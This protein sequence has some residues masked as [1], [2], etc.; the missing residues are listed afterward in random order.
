MSYDAII[1]GL[2]SGKI[3]LAIANFYKF[4]E[5]QKTMEFSD[6]YLKNDISVLVRRAK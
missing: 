5:R 3:D 6:T 2:R 1:A 4:E